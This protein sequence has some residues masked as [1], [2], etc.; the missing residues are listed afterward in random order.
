MGQI[1]GPCFP[2]NVLPMGVPKAHC[3][4]AT[5]ID[6]NLVCKN[7]FCQQKPFGPGGLPP[8]PPPKLPGAGQQCTTQGKCQPGLNC[9]MITDKMGV[10]M[11]PPTPPPKLPGAGQQCTTQGKC[12]P[13]LNCHMITDKMGVCMKPPAPL[14][15]LPGAGQQCTTQG[16]C[17]PGLNCHMITDKMGVCMKPPAPGQPGEGQRC[18]LPNQFPGSGLRGNCQSGLVCKTSGDLGVPICMKPTKSG[19]GSK[20]ILTIIGLIFLGLCFLCGLAKMG[21]KNARREANCDK[22]CGAFVFLG[23]ALIAVSSVLKSSN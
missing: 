16:K 13:G 14:P 11:K 10:C 3:G 23:V 22:A 2:P 20:E 19:M 6:P 7:G 4:T 12:Q 9:H 8:T 18:L 21:M 17:Q 1:G 15:K 5:V